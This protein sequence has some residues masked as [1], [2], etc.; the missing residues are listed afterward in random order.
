VAGREN[1]AVGG[2]EEAARVSG[3][4]VGA[5]KL[6]VYMLSGLGGGIAVLMSCGYS[7]AANTGMGQ[8]YELTV[9]AAAVVGGASL[10][11]GRGTA[12]GALLGALVIKLIE[13]GILILK[14]DR[15]Y[16]SII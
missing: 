3:L 6:R 14:W 1:Y 5:I 15:D 12:L 10:A 11:G 7:G 4:K 13:N 8:G 2:N 16:S 9:I